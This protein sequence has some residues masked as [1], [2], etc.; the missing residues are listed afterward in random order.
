MPSFI[1]SRTPADYASFYVTE[2]RR[3]LRDQADLCPT[4]HGHGY[5]TGYD[6]HGPIDFPCPDCDGPCRTP[7][8][9]TIEEDNVPF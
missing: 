7:P 9:A 8:P 4:C 6:F 1:P 3:L 5:V 2:A